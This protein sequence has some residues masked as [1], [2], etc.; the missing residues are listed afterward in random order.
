MIFLIVQ[1]KFVYVYYVIFR[2]SK[3]MCFHMVAQFV[4]LAVF[5]VR[6]RT[7]K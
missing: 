7:Y 5:A 1:C 4:T 2:P 3:V 6:T